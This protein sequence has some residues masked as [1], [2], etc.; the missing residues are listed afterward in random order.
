LL[1][2]PVDFF[3]W[4]ESALGQEK[5]TSAVLQAIAQSDLQFKGAIAQ[6]PVASS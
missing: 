5:D 2:V 4:F 6:V 1:L 3:F